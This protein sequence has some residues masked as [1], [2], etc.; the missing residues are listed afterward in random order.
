MADQKYVHLRGT[1]YPDGTRVEPGETAI[2][3]SQHVKDLLAA[4][5]IAKPGSA[6]ADAF[7]AEQGPPATD[8]TDGG[9]S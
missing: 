5:I 3:P 9:E 6:E 8:P 1:D 2:V 4:G 7:L